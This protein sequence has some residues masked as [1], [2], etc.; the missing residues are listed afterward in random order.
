[1]LHIQ[2]T[3]LDPAEEIKE[4]SRWQTKQWIEPPSNKESAIWNDLVEAVRKILPHLKVQR[5]VKH[6][7]TQ[8]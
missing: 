3:E 8:N 6:P 7:M 5:L 1:M 4:Q 2:R